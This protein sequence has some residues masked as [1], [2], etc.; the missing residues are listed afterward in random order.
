MLC[1]ILVLRGSMHVLRTCVD[2]HG[3]LGWPKCVGFLGWFKW[4]GC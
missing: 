1:P 4:L 2:M 3:E